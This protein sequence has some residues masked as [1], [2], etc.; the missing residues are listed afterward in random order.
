V[1][2]SVDVSDPANVKVVDQ[3]DFPRNGWE[4][5][6]TVTPSAIYLASSGYD[7]RE[8]NGY[9]TRIR[10]VDISDPAGHI[11]VRGEAAVAGRVQDRWSMDEYQ[12]ALR[13]ASG[14]S[15]GNGDVY[16]TTF[17]V[18][19]PDQLKELG[20][21]VLHVNEQLTSARFDGSRG[22]LVS[23]ERID[24]LFAF[25]LSDPAKPVLLD[26][27]KMTG[28]LDFMVPMG[29]RLVALGHED[30]TA[31]DGKRT[32]S[33]A[34]SLI[35]VAQSPKLLSR[36]TLDGLWG[37]V[38]ATRDDFAK[39]FR[40]LPED[41]LIVFPFQAWSQTDW[42][43]I[44][45]VQL[46]DLDR[47]RL[48]LRGLIKDAGW[49]ERGV[50]YDPTTVLTISSEVFQVM[51][52]ADRDAPRLRGHLELSRNV[53]E[54][55]IL[56]GSSTVQLAG[57]WYRGSFE[58]LTTS[59]DDPNSPEPLG[60]LSLGAPYGRMFV[61][62]TMAYVVSVQ[63]VK[64]T[65]GVP[66]Q[67]TVVQVV[68]VSDPAKPV[69]R[70]SVA[71]PET[72][73]PGYGYWHW[74]WGDE[75]AQL[76]GST[77][78]FHRFQYYFWRCLDCPVDAAGGDQDTSQKIY[79]VDLK[80][81]DA[82][83]VASTV[84]L[85]EEDSWA[86]GLRA[87]D[88]TLYLSSYRTKQG[89]DGSWETRYYL[90]RIGAADPADPVV[91]PPVNI[92]GYFVGASADNQIIYSQESLWTE[93]PT[94]T[95]YALALIDDKAYL[96]SKVELPGY[97]NGFE[98]AGEAA[99]STNYTYETVVVGEA[100]QWR[101]RSTLLAIDLRDP[102]SLRLA[103]KAELP[104]DYAYLQKVSEGRAFL[105]SGAGIFVY[106]V[107]DLENLVFENFFRT[108]GWSQDIDVSGGRAYVTSGYYGVQVLDLEV[109]PS[110]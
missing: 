69:K 11:K 26:E 5:H 9:L 93:T 60:R 97:V 98:V 25:D 56:P 76:N 6:L 107:S 66:Q 108:Q 53:Q 34:V 110:P 40:T 89:G 55:A 101:G 27:L 95:F 58:L 81:P 12:G 77:L 36:V 47:D 33:L 86:W 104:Y 87:V 90:Q 92:P 42:R 106:Q 91:H 109:K 50:P 64:T 23:Y 59:L 71:L 84:S 54:F 32:I 99:F 52:I 74:G 79:L 57:D 61:N 17:S 7:S 2:L 31:P 13:V 78:A 18:A 22:Y 39:V 29:D 1:V 103:G 67:A 96:Q 4:H 8:W 14:Q 62:G 88:T 105:G 24:P 72:V 43:Y 16:L 10:Y 38:P 44:G 94:T 83:A 21:Y 70:G 41:R 51:D 80:D 28:W 19:D 75:V 35:D 85:P 102:Q 37:W 3:E 68:D 20:K 73:W 45:G 63:E 65:D 100:I 48:T 46:I 82:P 49:V 15:W 30:L